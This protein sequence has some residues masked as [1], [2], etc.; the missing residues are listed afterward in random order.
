M[1]AAIAEFYT[2]LADERLKSHIV[3]FH[4]RFLLIHYR[5]GR[6]LSRSATLLIMVKSTQL[7]QTVTG[8]WRVL[9]NLKTHYYQ[10]L[11]SLTQSLTVRGSILQADNMLE[12][13]VGVV[14]IYSVPYV[15]SYHQLQQNVETL[16][17]DLRAFYEFN[18]KHM[19]AWDGPAGPV[20]QD[21]RHAICML[22]R[23]G[24]R[25]ALG[26]YQNDYIGLGI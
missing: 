2:D 26:N 1:P 24:L 14:W 10:V 23:N 12:I 13:L 25:P 18:S 9:P 21:G 7:Q 22:D 17:A 19:E 8:R 5:V 20:I 11:L 6:W 16:D 4:Q 3:V 15:C